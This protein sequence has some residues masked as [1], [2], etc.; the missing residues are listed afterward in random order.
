MTTYKRIEAVRKAGEVL[1][2]LANQ[3]EPV[4]GPQIAQAV[5]LAVGTTMCHLATLEDL[6]FVQTIGDRFRIGMGLA[7]VWA[8]AKSNLEAE[9][10]RIDKDLESINN[11]KKITEGT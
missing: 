4:T 10:E 9:R 11:S 2:Y 8:R 5:N 6:G 7:L 1:K 3:K